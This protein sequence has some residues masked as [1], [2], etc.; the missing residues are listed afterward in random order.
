MTDPL[1]NTWVTVAEALDVEV[2]TAEQLLRQV[3]ASIA[4]RDRL[5]KSLEDARKATKRLTAGL[6]ANA[7]LLNRPYTDEPSLSPWT[8]FIKPPIDDLRTALGMREEQRATP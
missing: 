7:E 1:A 8:R 2:E 3:V 4:E 6:I 5:R